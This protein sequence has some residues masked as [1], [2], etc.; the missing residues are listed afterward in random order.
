MRPCGAR[1][2]QFVAYDNSSSRKKPSLPT[3]SLW[4]L[5]S[6]GAPCPRRSLFRGLLLLLALLPTASL[7]AP[8]AEPDDLKLLAGTWK[9]KEA[10]LGDNKIDPLLLETASIVYAGDKY[11]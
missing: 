7:P 9:P 4:S 11:T 8:A 5:T 10:N 2:W 3:H 1:L 6:C